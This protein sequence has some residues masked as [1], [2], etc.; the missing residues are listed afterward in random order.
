[1]H[2]SPDGAASH[3]LPAGYTSR[4]TPRREAE[5]LFGC[6]GELLGLTGPG[7]FAYSIRTFVAIAIDPLLHGSPGTAPQALQGQQDDPVAV[8]LL[9]IPFL[10][11]LFPYVFKILFPPR[12]YFH[13]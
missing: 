5:S 1:M 9:G 8:V 11:H 6:C 2:R 12:L 13:A 4:Q 10:S 3:R 7:P